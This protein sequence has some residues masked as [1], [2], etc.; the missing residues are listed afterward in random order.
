M[1]WASA[2]APPQVTI[3][4][5]TGVRTEQV[6]P[7]RDVTVEGVC[8]RAWTRVIETHDGLSLPLFRYAPSS[9]AAPSFPDGP[10]VLL[11]HG[12]TA[13]SE[14][15]VMPTRHNL[16]QQLLA[17]GHDVW[18]LDWRGGRW[19]S[20]WYV[21]APFRRKITFDAAADHDVWTALSVMAEAGR[22]RDVRIGGHCMGSNITAMAVALDR[23]D[24]MTPAQR[25]KIEITAIQLSTI[26][27]YYA[28]P[29]DGVLRAHDYVLERIEALVPECPGIHCHG[30]PESWPKRLDGRGPLDCW[31]QEIDVAYQLWPARLLP[32]TQAARGEVRPTAENDGLPDA[33][34]RLA[35]M[36]GRVVLWDALD[37][38]LKSQREFVRQFGM[39]PL[40]LYMHAGQNV[41]RGFVARYGARERPDLF[42]SAP[43]GVENYMRREPFARLQRVTLI[44]G[45]ENDLWHR[46]ALD[47]ME[48]FLRAGP[49]DPARAVTCE[50]HV[51]PRFSHQDLLWGA[52]REGDGVRALY[53]EALAL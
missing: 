21:D 26:G 43:E 39:M 29:W 50:K 17:R 31:P 20:S 22:G 8:Y 41:R 12:A 32:G 47:R 34:T 19:V 49:T 27:L 15:F 11:L 7:P 10:P 3:E 48:Q 52:G 42:A 1:S 53:V 44:T 30:N 14:S 6:V 13:W 4:G 24:W 9:D 23:P 35:F 36:F 25:A 51:V 18:L 37:D 40:H 46:E 16:V 45:S 38:E 28:Q 2:D 5:E 33:F